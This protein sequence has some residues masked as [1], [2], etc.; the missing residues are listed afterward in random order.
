[1]EGITVKATSDY[2]AVDPA[3][4]E[5]QTITMNGESRRWNLSVPARMGRPDQPGLYGPAAAVFDRF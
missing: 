5:G 4:T 3:L 2:A 1:M